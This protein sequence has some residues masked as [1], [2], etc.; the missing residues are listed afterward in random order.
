MTDECEVAKGTG[1]FRHPSPAPILATALAIGMLSLMDAYMKEAALLA[2]ALMASFV[3][4][5]AGVSITAPIWLATGRGRPTP[6]AMRVHI[7]RGTV[8]A[9]MMTTF[10]FALTRLRLAEA[11][12]ISFIAPVVALFL[13]RWMLGEDVGKRAFLG[14]GM[15]VIGMAVIV[16]GRLS[17]EAMDAHNWVGLASLVLSAVLYAFNLVLQRRQALLARPVEIALFQNLIVSMVLGCCVLTALALRETLWAGLPALLELPQEAALWPIAA[18]A[19]LS[20]SAQLLLSWSYARAEAQVLV[21][22]EYSG[23]VW[24]ALFGWLF[25]GELVTPAVVGGAALIVAGC[26]IAAL[27][28]SKGPVSEQTAL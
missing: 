28:R 19:L 4:N 11:I 22:M 13:A 8:S 26:W 17:N 16:A 24:A 25:F 9:F 20:I 3:R 1:M 27:R 18:S 21:P 12:A 6:E 15:C 5:V 7:L 23:L 10:F 14:A 2:G